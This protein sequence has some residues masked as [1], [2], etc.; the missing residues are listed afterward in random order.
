M[1]TVGENEPRER[2]WEMNRTILNEIAH[3][4]DV[5]DWNE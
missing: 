2:G 3:D 4:R 5:G 1:T